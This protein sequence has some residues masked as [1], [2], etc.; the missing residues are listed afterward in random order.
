[1]L[2]ANA[3]MYSLNAATREAWRGLLQWVIDRA[4]VDAEVIDYPAPQPLPALWA[5]ADLGCAFMCGYPLARAQPTP[6]VLAAPRPSPARYGGQAVYRTHLVVRADAGITHLD[7]AWGRRMAYTTPDSMSGYHA[8]RRFFAPFAQAAAPR[9]GKL[10]SATVGPLLT[11]RGVVDAL[12]AGDADLGPLDSYAFDLLALHEPE[13]T[14]RLAV[15]GTTPATPIP[16]L[17]GAS[18]LAP[19]VAARLTQALLDVEAAPTM[20][21]QRAA[22]LL[23]GFARISA[24]AYHANIAA[25]DQADALGYPQLA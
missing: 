7:Q 18:T 14:A 4:A 24:A 10:F 12:L 16:A 13:L 15:I 21:P 22:L 8:P 20:A 5:R 11:P 3:R 17:V 2:I 6:T 9:G 23:H 1:M 19:A 25:A